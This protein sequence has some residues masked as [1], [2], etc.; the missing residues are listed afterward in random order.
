MGDE[1]SAGHVGLD[2]LEVGGGAA[3]FNGG[4]DGVG[5]GEGVGVDGVP[6]GFWW[7]FFLL[8]M[9]EGKACV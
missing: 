5:D 7:H 3:G 2:L 8:G 6:F 4:E 1:A 9:E